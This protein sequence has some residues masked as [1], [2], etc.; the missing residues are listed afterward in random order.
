MLCCFVVVKPVKHWV[1]SRKVLTKD[2]LQRVQELGE[3]EGGRREKEY[4]PLNYTVT[5]WLSLPCECS[6]KDAKPELGLCQLSLSGSSQPET[7]DPN[8]CNAILWQ[9]QLLYFEDSGH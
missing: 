4:S 3:G 9:I 2:E 6:E 5:Y 1:V 7:V 8:A